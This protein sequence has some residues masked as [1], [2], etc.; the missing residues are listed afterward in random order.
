MEAM[1]T[2]IDHP[3]MT[4]EEMAQAAGKLVDM[5]GG[6]TYSRNAC[7]VMRLLAEIERLQTD[8]AA[9][10]G[11]WRDLRDAATFDEYGMFVPIA[12]VCAAQAMQAILD[13]VPPPGGATQEGNGESPA[14]GTA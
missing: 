5:L 1:T 2:T 4:R 13:A 12:A 7:L 9:A 10:A 11:A 8:L 6:I 14:T 3:P